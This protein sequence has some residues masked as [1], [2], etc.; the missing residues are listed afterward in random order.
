M[1]EVNDASQFYR[2]TLFE[3]DIATDINPTRISLAASDCRWS[4]PPANVVLLEDDVHVWYSSLDLPAPSLQRFEATLDAGERERAK[5][6]CFERER[7]RFVAGRGLLR[8]ILGYYAGVEPS[9]LDF[10]YSS[11]GKPSLTE[12]FGGHKIQFNLAHSSGRAIYAVALDREIGVDLERVVPI[13]EAGQIANRFFSDREKAALHSLAESEKGEAF[14]KIWT[15]KE[16]YLKAC[17]KGLAY[18]LDKIDV[19]L[20]EEESRR[21]LKIRA[22]TQEDSHWSL[23]QL[24]PASGFTAA[25]V[26]E[27]SNYRLA[28]WQW[29]ELQVPAHTKK[30]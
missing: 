28:S 4:Q 22:R 29:P 26:V 7:A 17:G 13:V 15:A 23:E 11:H 16:A 5:R 1:S 27:G 20:E 12:R 25:V 21:S 19:S 2:V 10:Y 30:Y 8:S 24:R 9:G 14:F 18:P 6:F 3:M